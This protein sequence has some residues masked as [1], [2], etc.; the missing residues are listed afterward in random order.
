MKKIK[1]DSVLSKELS[2]EDLDLIK[3]VEEL[4][5]KDL[6]NQE[7]EVDEDGGMT[8]AGVLGVNSTSDGF[9]DGKTNFVMPKKLKHIDSDEEVKILKR[10]ELKEN[11]KK[12]KSSKKT[13][14]APPY[15]FPIDNTENN[16]E[17][18]IGDIAVDAGIAVGE[19]DE[20]DDESFE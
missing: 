6:I 16:S 17:N 4:L 5:D 3:Q 15:W 20:E 19:S 9:M 10:F 11:S 2:Q 7:K 18:D 13:V 1:E 12:K 8:S 14:V